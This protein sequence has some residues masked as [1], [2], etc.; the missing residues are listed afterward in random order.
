MNVFLMYRDRDLDPEQE[1]LSNQEALRRDL[2]LDTML[3]AMAQG[4]DFLFRR[5]EQAVLSTP[6]DPATICYR[7]DILKDCLRN[8][9][10]VRE[11]YAISVEAAEMKRE[12]WL[13]LA[14]TTPAS[15]LIGGLRMLEAFLGLLAGIRQMADQHAPEF[16]SEGFT[17]FCGMIKEELDDEYFVRLQDHLS[18]L[19]FDDGALISVELG[20]GNE[21][22]NYT[23][24]EPEGRHGNW[25]R[26]VFSRKPRTCG[27]RIHPRDHHGSRALS[28]LKAKGIN[29]VAN[30]VAQSADHVDDFLAALRIEL[31]FF[32]GCLNL[33][34]QLVELGEPIAF[35]EPVPAG[36]REHSFTGLY[37]ACLALTMKRCVVGNDVDAD[38]KQLVVITGAN[39][40]GKSTFLRSVGLAQ[41]MMESGMFVPA[42]SLRANVSSGCFSHF[43]REE[44]RTLESGKLDEELGRMSAIVDRMAPDA[45]ILLNESFSATNPREGSE[46][47]RQI[48]SALVDQRI[49]AF[50]VTHLHEFARGLY[51]NG[52][53]GAMFLRAERTAGGERTFRMIEGQ[54]LQTSYGI[55]LYKN[56]FPDGSD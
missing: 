49:K 11:L 47:A 30:A 5:A 52:T 12:H 13:G 34:D 26:K 39:Q 33:H 38:G 35:P 22:T 31:G 4:D 55:D 42:E 25:I 16:R 7:Q 43:R 2:E 9:A 18:E 44:D 46:I 48:V 45:L 6:D 53:E 32:V 27:F 19:R 40:G 17:R 10:V 21:G 50:F 28:E 37:D 24:R 8:P 36:R 54:P 51:D 3:E 23:L 56:V 1:L 29:L 15:V 41:L 14:G 20:R